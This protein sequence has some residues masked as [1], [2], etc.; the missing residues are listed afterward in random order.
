[1]EDL[2]KKDNTILTD[3]EEEKRISNIKKMELQEI[4]IRQKRARK[5]RLKEENYLIQIEEEE[6]RAIEKAV[7]EKIAIIRIEENSSSYSKGKY[8]QYSY[9][10]RYQHSIQNIPQEETIETESSSVETKDQGRSISEI[11]EHM[12]SEAREQGKIKRQKSK[13]TDSYEKVMEFYEK[14]SVGPQETTYQEQESSKK[15]KMDIFKDRIRNGYGKIK[16]HT[17]NNEKQD[18]KEH[19]EH[20]R[21]DWYK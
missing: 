5:K 12:N 18:E 19:V 15:S 21:H 20:K 10:Q 3:D 16:T 7:R 2:N 17:K 6:K 4:I 9:K 8:E 13:A 1:M 14:N 11:I